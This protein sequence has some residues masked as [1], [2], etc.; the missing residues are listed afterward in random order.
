M[1]YI[2][3][4]WSRKDIQGQQRLRAGLPGSY[5]FGCTAGLP[6]QLS[7]N[8]LFILTRYQCIECLLDSCHAAQYN[9]QAVYSTANILPYS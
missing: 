9:M 3:L 7:P 5:K 6:M 2:R 1:S 8:T 4:K